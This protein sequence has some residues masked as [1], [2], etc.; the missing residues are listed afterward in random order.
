MIKIG[1]YFED[2]LE[3][4]C[5]LIVCEIINKYKSRVIEKLIGGREIKYVENNSAI[6]AFFNYKCNILENK[7]GKKE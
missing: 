3:L 6:T 2:C 5:S 4:G 1:D 7:N